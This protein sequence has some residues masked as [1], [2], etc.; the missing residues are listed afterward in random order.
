M[1]LIP[2]YV[3][4]LINEGGKQNFL[5]IDLK[6]NAY[7]QFAAENGSSK[8]YCEVSGSNPLTN[9]K[10]NS[11]QI[12]ALKQLHWLPSNSTQHN[13]YTQTY[14]IHSKEDIAH[15]EELIHLTAAVFESPPSTYIYHLNL[16]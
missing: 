10:L 13:N 9:L 11:A 2:I 3:Q 8:I 5:I 15:L 7:I 14:S 12:E 16:A 4:Q 1:S 6:N